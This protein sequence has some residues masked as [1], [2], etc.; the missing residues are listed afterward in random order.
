[1]KREVENEKQEYVRIDSFRMVAAFLIVAI[2]TAPFVSVNTTLDYLF[3][4][5]IGRI[6]VPFFLMVTGYFV[7]APYYQGREG[8]V[9]RLKRYL[10]KIL[11]LY[12]ISI[13]LYLP[14]NIYAEQLP[15]NFGELCRELVFDGTFYH[16][17]YLPATVTGCLF[18]I[19]LMKL[20]GNKKAGIAAVL[21]Y[22]IGMF[23]DSYYGAICEI[24]LLKSIYEGIFA[25]SSYTR[26]GI[27]YVPVFLWLGI[28]SAGKTTGKSAGK[29][30]TGE[31][32]FAEGTIKRITVTGLGISMALML[33]EGF[34]TWHYELQR[35]NSMYLF[36]M[37]VMYFLFQ[38]LLWSNS[39]QHRLISQKKKSTG[40]QKDYRK[41][42]DISLW[43]YIIHPLCII[44]V[45]G[46]AKVTGIKLL[47]E[48][49]VIHYLLVSILAV[50]SA[51][52]ISWLQKKG[53]ERIACIK[54]AERG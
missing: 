18:L 19:I 40:K 45:R 46:L 15:E 3:T 27:F 53:K 4:Y 54:R 17:W 13:L 34:L 52:A 24:P 31:G 5:C 49:S 12:G 47:A 33:T 14:V 1:M 2:H 48:N 41:L 29:G 35:H 16:L 22:L 21:L 6:G 26:N 43:I 44:V 11:S 9:E 28:Q 51:A 37:P 8:S 20:L 42:R 7:L 38:L 50:I 39:S 32:H 30:R 36:L 25:V 10:I 23:G